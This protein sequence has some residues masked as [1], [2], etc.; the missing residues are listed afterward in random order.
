MAHEFEVES[1]KSEE[2]RVRGW[3]KEVG[4]ALKREK[5]YREKTKK[6][7]RMY[8][9]KMTR[10]QTF[11]ILYGNTETLIPALY[12][13]TPRPRVQRRFKD[14]DPMGK[15]V[16]RVTKRT[17]EFLMDSG[18]PE[19]SDFDRLMKQ[20]V[21]EALVPGRGVTRFKYDADVPPEQDEKVNVGGQLE[22][23]PVISYE[24]VCG[25]EV[26]WD[27]FIH[28]YAKQWNQVPWIGFIHYMDREELKDNF[29]AEKGAATGLTGVIDY[30]DRER[31]ADEGGEMSGD[32]EVAVVYEI[33][34]KKSRKV[35]FFSEGYTEGMLKERE[36]P[37][38]LSGFYPIPEPMRFCPQITDLVPTSLY[39]FYEEQAKEL[40]RITKRINVLVEGLKIRGIYDSSI[41]EMGALMESED[42]TLVPTSNLAAL[43]ERSL[44]DSI[45]LMPIERTITVLQQLYQQREQVKAVIYEITGI[46]DILRGQSAASESATAQRIK[47]EWGNLRIR[48]WQREV[49]RY[50]KDCLR[51][52]AEIAVTRIAPETLAMMTGLQYPDALIKQQAEQMLQ[53]FMSAP[54]EAQ[55]QIQQDP[56]FATKQ[57]EVQ[58]ILNLPTWDDLMSVLRD[59]ALRSYKVDIET[60]STL[61]S[62]VS[63]DKENMSEFVNAI[64]QFFLAVTPLIENGQLPF[65]AAQA[66]LMHMTRRF[67]FGTEVE[68]ELAKMQPPQQGADPEAEKAIEEAVEARTT[69]LEEESSMALDVEKQKLQLEFQKRQ[70]D[71]ELEYQ[72][73]LLELQSEKLMD[74][75][76]GQVDAIQEPLKQEVERTKSGQMAFQSV[77]Q[78][79][80][81]LIQGVLTMQQEMVQAVQAMQQVVQMMVQAQTAPRS[82]RDSQGREFT[83]QTVA[84]GGLE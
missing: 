60:N 13:I 57:A 71:L 61:D 64:S 20:A 59:D 50:A 22:D 67:N 25:Q 5:S 30:E 81:A 29:G 44:E 31:E 19:Y 11:N 16:S 2:N 70:N 82:I 42:N 55:Q 58:E 4:A 78:N 18:Q 21:V 83:V 72:K 27:R 68:D 7:V 63:E 12:S 23:V 41:D 80:Q 84:S 51:I 75:I 46:S 33:W 56:S 76:K 17:L 52:M 79:Q 8:E 3:L 32:R 74:D 49:Q 73:K 54:P 38:Q 62:D 47:N 40:N 45:F 48:R 43:A 15:H 77:E 26:P 53:A 28:G 65:E 35:L 1:G 34:D 69:E 39:T 24:T 6:I 66:M 36:D 9:G 10:E 14:E 37:F